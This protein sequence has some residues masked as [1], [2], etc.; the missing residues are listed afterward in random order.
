MQRCTASFVIA[1]YVSVRRTPQGLA[2]LASGA[3]YFAA[4][5][6]RF[7]RIQQGINNQAKA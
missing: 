5:T 6:L 3:F 1:A 2:R 7:L 4:F